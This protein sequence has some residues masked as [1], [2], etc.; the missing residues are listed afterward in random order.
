MSGIMSLFFFRVMPTSIFMASRVDSQSIFL[1]TMLIEFMFIY[2]FFS[3]NSIQLSVKI[4][5]K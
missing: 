4:I 1:P 3:Y 5:A 2:L